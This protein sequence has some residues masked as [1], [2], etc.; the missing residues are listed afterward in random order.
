MLK[1][2]AYQLI[3]YSFCI[4]SIH[5]ASLVREKTN[6]I[7]F[8]FK[9]FNLPTEFTNFPKDLQHEIVKKLPNPFRPIRP[10]PIEV[11]RKNF[12]W[13]SIAHNFHN[14]SGIVFNEAGTHFAV[15]GHYED[16]NFRHLT[17]I[18]GYW[19]NTLENLDPHA[20]VQVC[21]GI[22]QMAYNRSGTQLL[23]LYKNGIA[24][25][26]TLDNEKVIDHQL[27]CEI[28]IP[29]NPTA[30]S[31]L[32]DGTFLIA[33]SN[34]HIMTLDASTGTLT[35]LNE[36]DKVFIA[37][38]FISISVNQDRPYVAYKDWGDT[39]LLTPEVFDVTMKT[40]S[41][42][43]E[44]LTGKNQHKVNGF[45]YNS[46]R[47]LLATCD[48]KVGLLHIWD[49]TGEIP[50]L[51]RPPL[52]GTSAP[53]FRPDSCYALVLNEKGPKE[54][55]RLY[56]LITGAYVVDIP[57]KLAEH[58]MFSPKGDYIVTWSTRGRHGILLWKWNPTWDECASFFEKPT[59]LEQYLFL[60]YLHQL[61]SC[62]LTLKDEG[63]CAINTYKNRFSQIIST[64]TEQDLKQLN[65]VLLSFD[66]FVQKY[67][68][69][70]YHLPVW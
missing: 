55:V 63:V 54:S 4:P 27:C 36:P 31:A 59:T 13:R 48:G 22:T 11:T 6:H 20:K 47:S 7:P 2:W 40:W 24:V 44:M 42:L 8:L 17:K 23:V 41:T 68:R 10:K 29:T 56:S 38:D 12:N 9:E 15:H 37:R 52:S 62:G 34:K 61:G 65:D 64:L 67:L 39:L 5:A 26:I 18:T 32:S 49:M 70:K 50:L 57:E 58:H 25:L 19:V 53:C 66:P 33:Y 60:K 1:Y 28:D 21:Q 16:P 30:I 14:A 69:I 3:V 51:S 45:C 46:D 35:T 43:P